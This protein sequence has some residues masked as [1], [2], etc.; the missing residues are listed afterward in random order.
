MLLFRN[1]SDRTIDEDEEEQKQT[2][3]SALLRSF[4]V[5]L[6]MVEFEG[7][8]T[9]WSLKVLHMLIHIFWLV[10]AAVFSLYIISSLVHTQPK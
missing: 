4:Q 2:S 6:N 3:L 1:N 5:F 8:I 10:A 7:E 9:S